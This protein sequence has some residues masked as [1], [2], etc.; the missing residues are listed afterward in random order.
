MKLNL[1]QTWEMVVHGKISKPLPP[2]EKGIEWKSWLKLLSINFQENPSDWDLPVDNL[3]CKASS[4]LYIL[5]P[6]KYFGHPKEQLTKLF[7]LLT[8]SLFSYGFRFGEWHIKV[9]TLIAL[10]GFFNRAFRFGYTNNLYVIAEV[11]RNRDCK[12]WNTI[13]DTPPHP[14]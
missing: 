11:I 13:T 2:L 3:L 5:W 10:T 14:L 8:M 9:N 7:D 6:C 12:L 4:H 1:T